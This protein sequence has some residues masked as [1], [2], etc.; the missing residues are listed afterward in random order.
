[1]GLIPSECRLFRQE[2]RP[3][4]CAVTRGD[5]AAL[6]LAALVPDDEPDLTDGSPADRLI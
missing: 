4:V 3:D 5:P 1:M 6:V 2:H